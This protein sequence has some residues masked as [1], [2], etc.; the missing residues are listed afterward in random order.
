M[1]CMFKIRDMLWKYGI[2]EDLKQIGYN[3]VNY[4]EKVLSIF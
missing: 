4:K 2:Q 3:R 1:F